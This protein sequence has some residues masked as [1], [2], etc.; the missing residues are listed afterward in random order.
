VLFL[1]TALAILFFLTLAKM[2][3]SLHPVAGFLCFHLILITNELLYVVMNSNFKVTEEPNQ[4]G[5]FW[6]LVTVRVLLVPA[7]F[8]YFFQEIH[9]SQSLRAKAMVYLALYATLLLL[10]F[11]TLKTG[12]TTYHWPP[13]GTWAWIAGHWLVELIMMGLFLSWVNLQLQREVE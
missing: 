6:T 5:M 7:I 8:L 11:C 3:R 13:L 12:L 1:P 2:R 4:A 10:S 9:R